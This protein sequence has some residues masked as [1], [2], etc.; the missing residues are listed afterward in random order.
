MNPAQYAV[1][2]SSGD[3]GYLL[4][5]DGDAAFGAEQR[6][7]VAQLD[8]RAVSDVDGGEVHGNRADQW[9]QVSLHNHLTF[10]G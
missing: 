3:A 5:V 8:R 7:A 1:R 9:R 2:N 6:H 10:I 4:R